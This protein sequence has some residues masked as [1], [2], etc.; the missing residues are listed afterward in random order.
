MLTSPMNFM[1]FVQNYV[2]LFP[3]DKKVIYRILLENSHY[4]TMHINAAESYKNYYE[5]NVA[6]KQKKISKED[7]TAARTAYKAYTEELFA[8]AMKTDAIFANVGPQMW[9]A[10]K[11]NLSQL[12]K[13]ASEAK[14]YFASALG[15][16]D[17]FYEFRLDLNTATVD[18]FRMIG[19]AEADAAS[20]VKARNEKGFFKGNPV[21]IIN[22]IVGDERFAKYNAVLNLTPYDHTGA[23]VIAQAKEQA[24]ALWPEDIAKLT[25][26]R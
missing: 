6:Y 21:T 24:L 10:G 5:F 12:K 17:E 26:A 13:E 15:K 23:D 3:D 1:E 11:I 16:K 20:M 2:K 9:F 7:F 8:D 14:Q 25:N 22:K 18:M 19:F 4:V